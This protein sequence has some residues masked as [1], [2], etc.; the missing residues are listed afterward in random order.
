MSD[1]L[2]VDFK[3]GQK[4][5]VVSPVAKKRLGT[6]SGMGIFVAIYGFLITLFMLIAAFK[7]YG[8]AADLRKAYSVYGN[9][10]DYESPAVTMYN[11]IGTVFLI[12]GLLC[13]MPGVF[14][15]R[16]S[17]SIRHAIQNNDQYDF[18]DAV[19]YLRNAFISVGVYA[20]LML[21]LIACSYLGLFTPDRPDLS[22]F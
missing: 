4:E 6:I 9:M 18:E 11:T 13:I 12:I 2:D 7:L 8:E 3:A 22:P 19:K 5:I 20:G 14:L 1:N 16:Y 15:I 10:G 17:S 21:I